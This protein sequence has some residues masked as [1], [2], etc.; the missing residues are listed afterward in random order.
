M[1]RR[2]LTVSVMGIALSMAALPANARDQRGAHDHSAWSQ[3]HG[4]KRCHIEVSYDWHGAML[5]KR[6]CAH[7][8]RHGFAYGAPVVIR[9]PPVIVFQ[10]PPRVAY[11]PAPA[12]TP[13]HG[14]QCREY[15]TISTINGEPVEIY[16]T[17]CRQPDGSWRIV[18]AD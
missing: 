4:G 3:G 18:A 12:P 13:R 1:I 7:K 17:A 10:E 15:S 9:R 11:R 2:L 6:V 14:G 5:R 8:R 16:G